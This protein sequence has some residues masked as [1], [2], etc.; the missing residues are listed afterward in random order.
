MPRDSLNDL[1]RSWKHD[2]PSRPEFPAEVWAR[3]DRLRT[4]DAAR[5]FYRWA[6]PLAASIA[7]AFGVGS[8]MRQSRQ[9]HDDRMAADL[10][11]SVDPLQMTAHSHA[12]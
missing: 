7:L 10:V 4:K 5:S 1:L 9:E 8:A 11:R 2:P 6:L 3:I 12:P